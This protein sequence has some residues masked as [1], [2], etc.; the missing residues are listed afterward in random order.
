M[1]SKLGNTADEAAHEVPV[2]SGRTCK[3]F[4]QWSKTT[5][6]LVAVAA[7]AVVAVVI[8]VPVV[9]LTGTSKPI[10]EIGQASHSSNTVSKR[11]SVTARN[12]I[13]LMGTS[14]SYAFARI[15]GIKFTIGPSINFQPPSGNVASVQFGTPGKVLEISEEGNLQSIRE[16]VDLKPGQ[17]ARVEVM[18]RNYLSIKAYCKTNSSIVWTT[19]AGIRKANLPVTSDDLDQFGYYDY[20]FAFPSIAKS[21]TDRNA[22]NDGGSVSTFY[23][24]SVTEKSTV[25]MVLDSSYAI[26]CYDGNSVSGNISPFPSGTGLKSNSGVDFTTFFPLTSPNFGILSLPLF[27]YVGDNADRTTTQTYVVSSDMDA[28][29]NATTTMNAYKVM[30]ITIAFDPVGN[31]L[32]ANCRNTGGTHGTNLDSRLVH[33]L[34]IGAQGKRRATPLLLLWRP[35]AL[36]Q[37]PTGG[38][39]QEQSDR[40]LYSYNFQI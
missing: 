14:S 9:L 19:P 20:A 33:P 34:T 7:V 26:S 39:C 38:F 3:S 23:S 22:N 4:S 17:Y 28:L 16:P 30:I 15:V 29:G 11:A 21:A 27:V 25:K 31:F 37:W 1:E 24:F 18:M 10:L 8:V 12:P 36:G 5:K 13:D 2:K 32:G 6:I 40:C 35:Q